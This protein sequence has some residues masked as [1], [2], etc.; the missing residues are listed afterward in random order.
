MLCLN[1]ITSNPMSLTFLL[2]Y[3]HWVN[4]V[5]LKTHKRH[6][7]IKLR[8]LPVPKTFRTTVI[9]RLVHSADEYN[10]HG[11]KRLFTIPNVLSASCP[12]VKQDGENKWFLHTDCFT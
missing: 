4:F 2:F 6:D 11:A 10:L 1:K 8:V 5:L 7:M 3:M 9:G 12:S